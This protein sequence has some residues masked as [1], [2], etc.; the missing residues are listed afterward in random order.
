MKNIINLVTDAAS[1]KPL[2]L[3]SPHWNAVRKQHLIKEPMCR[4]CNGKEK[5]QVHHI[6]PFHLF[7][8]SEL[9][10]NNL[11]TLCEHPKTECHLILGHRGNFK[12]YNAEALDDIKKYRIEHLLV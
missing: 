4:A 12:K 9:D 1:G 10:P 3:R 2:A 8:E 6:K 5:L 11:V 7:P